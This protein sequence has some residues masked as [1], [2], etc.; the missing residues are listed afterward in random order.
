MGIGH[1]I[2]DP[3]QDVE[4]LIQAQIGQPLIPGMPGDPFHGV[5]GHA[6][7]IDPDIVDRD[8]VG[9]VQSAGHPGLGKEAPLRLASGQVG[10]H[11]LDGDGATQGRLVGSVDD[12]HAAGPD[13]LA[14]DII[15]ASAAGALTT[16]L[17]PDLQGIGEGGMLPTDAADGGP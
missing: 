4:V 15:E 1:A 14:Q 9:M 3:Q 10:A 2:G 6:V 16:H 17:A 12:A 5:E 13:D 8:D 7:L 11:A